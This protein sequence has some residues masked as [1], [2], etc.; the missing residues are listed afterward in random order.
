MAPQ[1]SLAT[2]ANNPQDP[3]VLATPPLRATPRQT[4]RRKKRRRRKK[5]LTPRQRAARRAA[6]LERVERYQ[7]P[8]HVLTVEEWCAL[9]SIS[10]PTGKRILKSGGGPTV[11][12]VG[13]HRIGITVGNNRRWQGSRARG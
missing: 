7:N 3:P 10:V 5:K 4:K 6:I 1:Q 13:K 9:N 8:D 12:E 11:T 2:P